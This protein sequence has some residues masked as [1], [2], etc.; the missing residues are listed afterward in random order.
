M[1]KTNSTIDSDVVLKWFRDGFELPELKSDQPWF[2]YS[3]D[4]LKARA[5]ALHIDSELTRSLPPTFLLENPTATL[6]A[7]WLTKPSDNFEPLQ[8]R[9]FK[10][11]SEP[12][13]FFFHG[14]F[15]FGGLD[16]PLLARTLSPI[17]LALIYQNDI[18]DD[19]F[20]KNVRKLAEAALP[21][22]LAVQSDGPFHLAGFCNGGILAQEVAHLLEQRGFQ[23][24][25]CGLVE[26]SIQHAF[27]KHPLRLLSR[28]IPSQEKLI[29]RTLSR[30]TRK[31]AFKPE[32]YQTPPVFLDSSLRPFWNALE[33]RIPLMEKRN[34]LYGNMLLQYRS[35]KLDCPVHFWFSEQSLGNLRIPKKWPCRLIGG[36]DITVH[37]VD[38]Q[39][40][41]WS[42]ADFSNVIRS[43]MP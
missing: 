6:A 9:L 32:R 43:L 41:Q 35:P 28:W 8:L 26:P 22:I 25:F 12:P 42:H 14:D 30:I 31:L 39:H 37:S 17:P 7:Q 5:A 15:N 18:L 13:L 21:L 10:G 27:I 24:T 29:R 4:P 33:K 11:S 36:H 2:E 20:P 3:Q 16:A 1:S 19:R 23:V 38:G 34:Q 40:D